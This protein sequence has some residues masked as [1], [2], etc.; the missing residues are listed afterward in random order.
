MLAPL[1]PMW[2]LG[3]AGRLQ[4]LPLRTAS[5]AASATHDLERRQLRSARTEAD[6][7]AFLAP[8]PAAQLVADVGDALTTERIALFVE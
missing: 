7:F 5:V 4:S 3:S 1:W 8:I 6:L 2:G